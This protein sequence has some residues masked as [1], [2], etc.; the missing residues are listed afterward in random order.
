MVAKARR[1]LAL[2]IGKNGEELEPEFLY[3]VKKFLRH[4]IEKVVPIRYGQTIT[5]DDIDPQ[6]FIVELVMYLDFSAKYYEDKWFFDEVEPL[7]SQVNGFI[8][9]LWGHNLDYN[10]LVSRSLAGGTLA[11]HRIANPEFKRRKGE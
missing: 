7:M 5:H 2:V 3:A 10:E 8:V 9:N 6:N 11:A 1:K 4:D